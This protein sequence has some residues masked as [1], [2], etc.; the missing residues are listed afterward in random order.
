ML[1][2][3]WVPV[4]VIVMTLPTK[5]DV[6][7]AYSGTCSAD[8]KTARAACALRCKQKKR[9]N[10]GQACKIR[11][12][13]RKINASQRPRFKVQ[14]PLA[15]QVLCMCWVP[16]VERRRTQGCRSL[17]LSV[18]HSVGASHVASCLDACQL[19]PWSAE[20]SCARHRVFPSPGLALAIVSIL[21]VNAANARPGSVGS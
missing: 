9:N 1:L 12:E 5:P 4:R 17:K 13:M 11:Y 2:C 21:S 16:T 3:K 19:L 18:S 14:P 15:F 8:A 10:G 6:H 7:L 20:H